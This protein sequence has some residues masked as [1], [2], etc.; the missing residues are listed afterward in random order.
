MSISN[1]GIATSTTVVHIRDGAVSGEVVTDNLAQ[2]VPVA[3]VYN[4]ISHAVMMA[5][6]ADLHDFALGFSISEGILSHPTELHDIDVQTAG[7][8]I[9]VEMRI[10]TQRLVELKE[11]R[12]NLVGRTGCGLCGAESLSQAMRPV[13]S[14]TAVAVSATAIQRA[15]TQ[16]PQYQ[17]LQALTGATHAAAWCNLNGDIVIAREDVGRHNALDKVIGA[18]LTTHGDLSQ[19]FVLISSR[20]SYEMVQKSCA[21]GIGALVAVS[22]ATSLAVDSARQAN[23]LLIGFGRPDR[24]VIYHQPAISTDIRRTEFHE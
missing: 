11:R 8:G 17:P 13:K 4:G 21:V 22:A 3:L 23:Q 24:H 1:T 14:V 16:L 20:A 15:L 12:R 6:P 9:S 7:Q 10:A 19:G 18:L 2:E 5:T